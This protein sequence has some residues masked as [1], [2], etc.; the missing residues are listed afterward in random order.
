MDNHA[1]SP[2]LCSPGREADHSTRARLCGLCPVAEVLGPA[3]G[4]GVARRARRRPRTKLSNVSL[5]GG[6]MADPVPLAQLA[7]PNYKGDPPYTGTPS[8]EP[9][10][11][12]V[13]WGREENHRLSG[14]HCRTQAH[15]RAPLMIQN[16]PG[17]FSMP[18]KSRFR[19]RLRR[20]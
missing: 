4:G 20:S 3:V 1:H 5:A 14:C 12:S 7:N 15:G 17:P 2:P 16:F 19:S 8:A 13:S 11:I 10:A 6:S 9:L 18:T